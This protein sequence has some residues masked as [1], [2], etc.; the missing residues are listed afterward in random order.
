MKIALTG[1]NGRIGQRVV[2]HALKRGHTVV[3]VDSS[4]DEPVLTDECL[5]LFRS[6]QGS[7]FS[8]F[9][10]QKVDLRNFE[11][12]LEV[13]AGCDAVIA[14]A[15]FPDP[16]D[17]R[18]Q[19]HNSN[20]VISWNILRACAELGITRIAQAL[21]IN[22][23]TMAYCQTAKHKCFPVDESHPC[24]PDEPYGLSKVIMEMQ[25]DTIRPKPPTAPTS[26]PRRDI[27][28]PEDG[29]KWRK[30]DLWGYVQIDSAAD[31]FLRA[32]TVA[33]TS[34]EDAG[35]SA[36]HAQASATPAED[37]A[38]QRWLKGGHE[39]FFIVAP[40]TA[41]DTPSED[42]WKLFWP[43]VALREGHK[44]SGTESFFDCGKAERMLGWVHRD[45][46]EE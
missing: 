21:S 38:T 22:V 9:S 2:F 27:A 35:H 6:S 11:E 19:T 28:N 17:Y 1:S 23:L 42:L 37:E 20:V 40:T 26:V 43:D 12:V 44:L 36:S 33:A 15:A 5:E 16:T 45:T 29:D 4:S 7:F 46:P 3:G 41:S 39:A 8:R 31:A 10:Y 32:V 30:K 34:L 18:V 13:L 14:L 25:A 24:E